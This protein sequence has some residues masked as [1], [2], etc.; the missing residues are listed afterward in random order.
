METKPQETEALKNDKQE[1]LK[2]AIE[3]MNAP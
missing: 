3:S 2:K 1:K